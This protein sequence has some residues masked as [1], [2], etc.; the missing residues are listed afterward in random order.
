MGLEE[1]GV[2]RLWSW[3]TVE[4]EDCGVGRLWSWKT[5]E[6][7]GFGET[8]SGSEGGPVDVSVS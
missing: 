6:L 5:V 4:L 2:G 7:G 3:K 8:L 1:Y